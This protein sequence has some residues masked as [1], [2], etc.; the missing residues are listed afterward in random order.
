V[1]LYLVNNLRLE[2]RIF[3]HA[4][5]VLWFIVVVVIEI[6]ISIHIFT[7]PEILSTQP[8]CLFRMLLIFYII[9]YVSVVLFV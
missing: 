9:D 3:N 1:K 8:L 2:E 7:L 5:L 6:T 4:E